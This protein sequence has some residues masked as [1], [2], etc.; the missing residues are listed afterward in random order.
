MYS[1]HLRRLLALGIAVG[2]GLVLMLGIVA[3]DARAGRHRTMRNVTV[4]HRNIGR[5]DDAGINRFID[6]LEGQY[7]TAPIRVAAPRGGFSAPGAAFGIAVDRPALLHDIRIRGRRGGLLSRFA[8]YVTSFAIH[9]NVEVP[10]TVD[11]S[12]IAATLETAD[13][14]ARRAPVDPKLVV[15]S[16]KFKVVPGTDGIGI[17]VAA[18]AAQIPKLAGSGPGALTVSVN[19]VVLPARYTNADAES[20]LDEA[21]RRTSS[22]LRVVVGDRG[23]T[24]SPS[25]LRTWIEPA[26]VNGSVT[27]TVDEAAA[28]T[29]IRKAI[30]TVGT[31]PKDA[32]LTVDDQG[33]VTA[34]ASQA[35]EVCCDERSVDRL[36]TALTAA[37]PS[38]SVTLD[39]KVVEPEVT[40]EEITEL[41]V[42]EKV[43]TFSTK[44][45]PGEDRVKNIHHIADLLRGVVI[46]PGETFSVNRTIGPRSAANGF[47]TAH[48]IEDGVFAENYG[49]GI[50]QF[51][52]TLFNAAFFGGLDLVEY[53]SHSLYISRY[54]YGREA[55]LSYPKPDLKIRNIT[56][57]GVMIWPTY[58]ART[59]TVD[60]Y[61]TKFVSG[62]VVSQKKEPRNQCTVVYTTRLRTYVDGRPPQT[63]VTRASYRPK[64]GVDCK[65]NPT[66]GATTTAP[67]VTTPAPERNEPADTRPATTRPADG[68]DPERPPSATRPAD[69]RPPTTRA[70]A[71]DPEPGS[72]RVPDGAVTPGRP[73]VTG[74]Q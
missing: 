39:L 35:G 17:P 4:A 31:P 26:I 24:I 32:R 45:A 71:P 54:P 48:V 59:I 67:R 65:G 19:R 41:G 34:I 64:E 40:T 9:R 46:P 27:L 6:Q 51:A 15:R 50:S 21:T 47:V 23:A 33:T 43:A 70:P 73:P 12:L 20:L 14:A 69:T 57:Y 42:K 16:S 2:A 37:D 29:G 58:T 55:T 28:L 8:S 18:V 7:R 36:N 62:D 44:H 22:P 11:P 72:T 52:T 56:P 25:Q 68:S 74:V 10:V 13:S 3:A 63:D 66:A 49:G 60:L 61:S 53:Q 1:L 5:M 38:A 30:G